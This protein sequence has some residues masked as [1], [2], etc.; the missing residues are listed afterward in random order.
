MGQNTSNFDD[1]ASH[2]LSLSNALL[3]QAKMG[4][5]TDFA[6]ECDGAT[7][8]VHKAVV[9]SQ[10]EAFAAACEGRFQEACTGVYRIDRFQASTVGYMVEYL[11]TGD[12]T[13]ESERKRDATE[14]STSK[15]ETTSRTNPSTPILS[16]ILIAHIRVADL[17]EYYQISG[18]NALVERKV[19]KT[20]Q[21]PW[22]AKGFGTAV[23]LAYRVPNAGSL[24]DKIAGVLVQHLDDFLPDE[25]TESPFT[26]DVSVRVLRLMREA[27]KAS[28]RSIHAL[29]G[30]CNSLKEQ[31]ARERQKQAQPAQHAVT[32]GDIL[33][34][35]GSTLSP[36]S[37]EL[38]LPPRRSNR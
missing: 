21:M 30:E 17:A 29:H 27:S 25:A 18:L 31:L 15:G 23:D 20:L 34:L 14:V 7:F 2:A 6:L 35:G 36:L 16:E 13:T 11:Y 28:A 38:L 12:Y 19:D 3:F 9:C 8:P 22:S 1:A 33:R 10:V 24:C 4:K 5:Y 32:S 26:D 37:R